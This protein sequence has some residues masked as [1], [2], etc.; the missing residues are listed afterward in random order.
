MRQ[1]LTDNNQELLKRKNMSIILIVIF[2]GLLGIWIMSSYFDFKLIW[3]IM[4]WVLS[5]L[6]ILENK[7]NITKH[8][9]II[10]II[11][12]ILSI[13]SNLIMGV[14]TIITFVAAMSIYNKSKN[15]IIFFRS[16]KKNV[17]ITLFI[18]LIT[19]VLLGT[20][21][22]YLAM[23]TMVI[24]I[25]FKL[26]WILD[27]LRA[28][29]TEEVLFRFFFFA[30][31]IK[32]TRDN[33]LNKFQIFMCYLIMIIP[34]SMAHF[35]FTTFSIPNVIIPSLLFGLPLTLSIMKRDLLTAM[36]IHSII[37]LLR[38]IIFSA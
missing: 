28:G 23:D 20:L 16:G 37:D 17:V 15:K 21:N 24:N 7:K 11:L 32:V 33:K 38:F 35:D 25:S 8:N 13:P 10:G 1:A 12:G 26:K 19:G 18:I 27:A 6:I 2:I 29:I 3:F 22:V 34:H 5:I 30:I 9:I 31:C 14:S 4:F 36:G